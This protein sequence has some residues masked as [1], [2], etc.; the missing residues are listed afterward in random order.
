MSQTT[1]MTIL[2][3]RA[4]TI[5]SQMTSPGIFEVFV[6]FE[7]PDGRTLGA[8][9][10]RMYQDMEADLVVFDAE[11]FQGNGGRT[12]YPHVPYVER[13]EASAPIPGTWHY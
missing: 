8:S 7:H 9:I 5:S 11:I 2:R 1:R 4:I 10:S 6:V 3:K 12:W 13:K